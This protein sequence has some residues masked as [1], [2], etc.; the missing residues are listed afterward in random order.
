MIKNYSVLPAAK[1]VREHIEIEYSFAAQKFL[2]IKGKVLA[3]FYQFLE[4]F[5]KDAS[6]EEIKELSNI[7]NYY[8]NT[9]NFS[10]ITL[11]DGEFNM[12][13]Y[14]VRNKNIVKYSTA[15]VNKAAYS[16]PFDINTDR[17]YIS[18]NGEITNWYLHRCAIPLRAG[19]QDY[20]IYA[21]IKLFAWFAVSNK[22]IIA[23]SPIVEIKK[24]LKYYK[25]EILQ[26][27]VLKIDNKYGEL[28]KTYTKDGLFS[29][30]STI[31][32]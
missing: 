12:H 6:D 16:L 20:T 19:K 10:P 22:G 27:N 24:L 4:Q 18:V 23:V 3:R 32:I 13:G 25:L 21:P 15:I 2:G 7:M 26:D 14:N 9:G 8:S 17:V 1:D 11:G 29:K 5:Y 31:Q 28:N 30:G